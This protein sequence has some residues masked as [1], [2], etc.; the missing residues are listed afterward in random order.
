MTMFAVIGLAMDAVG[1]GWVT[2]HTSS[3][4]IVSNRLHRSRA[5]AEAAMLEA[6]RE[7]L[8]GVG[9]ARKRIKIDRDG[10][11]VNGLT[12]VIGE[13]PFESQR[14]FVVTECEEPCNG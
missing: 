7:E 9:D 10:L 12:I 6:F 4:Y 2:M 1:W 14:V 11:E 5:S 3:A 8:S 13:R